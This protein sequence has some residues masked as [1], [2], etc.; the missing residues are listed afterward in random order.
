MRCYVRLLIVLFGVVL[1][2]LPHEGY[3]RRYQNQQVMLTGFDFS[4]HPLIRGKMAPYEGLF[5]PL[6]PE[7]KK[8]DHVYWW[9]KSYCYELLKAQMEREIGLIMMPLNS[10]GKQF[11]YDAYGFPATNIER[12]QRRG[13][14]RFYMRIAM[15]LQASPESTL[16]LTKVEGRDSLLDPKDY[17]RPNIKITVT[18]YKR[19]G[20][21]P[22]AVHSISYQWPTAIVLQPRM[23]DGI[24][25]SQIKRDRTTLRESLELAVVQIVEEIMHPTRKK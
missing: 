15:D 17:L 4:I 14:A 16:S 5:P 19:R 8:G 10:Y 12:A 24:V 6:P 22:L 23:L 3:A 21:V 18:F 25:N 11:S 1:L 20:I 7:V 2:V 13:D 9:M